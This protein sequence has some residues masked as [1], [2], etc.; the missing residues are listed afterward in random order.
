M[1]AFAVLWSVILRVCVLVVT[2]S[3]KRYNSGGPTKISPNR[4]ASDTANGFM[5]SNSIDSV[6]IVSQKPLS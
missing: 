3:V 4:T 1:H 6:I 5:M 2:A